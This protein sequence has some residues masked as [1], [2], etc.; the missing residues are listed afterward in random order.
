MIRLCFFTGLFF[1]LCL[2]PLPGIPQNLS[3]DNKAQQVTIE[4]YSGAG[5]S[6]VL[7]FD[8]K[9][10]KKDFWRFCNGFAKLENM[11]KYYEVVLPPGGENAD[12]SLRVRVKITPLKDRTQVTALLNTADMSA[13]QVAQYSSSANKLL[14]EFKIFFYRKWIQDSIALLEK[15]ARQWSIKERKTL[16]KLTKAREKHANPDKIA[17]LEKELNRISTELNQAITNVEIMK[18][19]LS[20]VK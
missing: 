7:D 15:E 4:E 12:A 17:T 13:A 8:Y 2:S 18:S 3:L 16:R 19:K 10:V 9:S 6:A 11:R 14:R 5:F 1:L 20:E